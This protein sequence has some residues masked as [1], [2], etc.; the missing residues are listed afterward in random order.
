MTFTVALVGRPNVGKSTICNTLMG[1][2][3]NIVTD[4]PGTT[5]DTLFVRYK[6]FNHDLYLVDT[7]GVRKKSKVS[8]D[9]EFYSVIIQPDNW[10]NISKSILP[11]L[12]TV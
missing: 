6:A 4:I 10:I 8:E 1:E 11:C 9:I 7:A 5:R 3:R 12:I 2:E